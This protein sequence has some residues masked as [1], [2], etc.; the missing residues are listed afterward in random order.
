M[1]NLKNLMN[2]YVAINSLSDEALDWETEEK[3]GSG[4]NRSIDTGVTPKKDYAVLRASL[5]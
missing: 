1:K 5:L 4:I 3:R 2:A